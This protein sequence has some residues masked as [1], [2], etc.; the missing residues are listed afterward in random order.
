MRDRWEGNIYDTSKERLSSNGWTVK[1]PGLAAIV[2]CTSKNSPSPVI[3][4]G[5]KVFITSSSSFVT[6]REVTRFLNLTLLL[7]SPTF[8]RWNRNDKNK[9]KK[10]IYICTLTNFTLLHPDVPFEL[11]VNQSGI[12]RSKYVVGLNAFK[13]F[14]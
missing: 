13:Q 1:F 5:F 12:D 14:Y 6:V 9:N 7:P 4:G 8:L 3:F 11:F 10:Y 2:T